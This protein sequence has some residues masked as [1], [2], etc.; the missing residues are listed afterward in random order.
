MQRKN[1][2]VQYIQVAAVANWEL[3][4]CKAVTATYNEDDVA[5]VVTGL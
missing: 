3:A 2:E 4:V 1:S 5:T